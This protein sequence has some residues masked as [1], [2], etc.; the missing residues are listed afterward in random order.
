[1]TTP[2]T[3][4]IT[5]TKDQI[6]AVSTLVERGIDDLEE[7]MGACPDEYTAEDVLSN[8]AEIEQARAAIG[9]LEAASRKANPE[10]DLD[11]VGTTRAI[12]VSELLNP[13]KPDARYDWVCYSE[14]EANA[15]QG[16]GYYSRE[17]GWTT[18]DQAD[19]VTLTKLTVDTPTP[20]ATGDD[21]QWINP[22]L[23]SLT[24]EESFNEALEHYCETFALPQLDARELQHQLSEQEAPDFNGST[25]HRLWLNRICERWEDLFENH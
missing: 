21:A 25:G 8:K 17:H 2:L 3:L 5:L 11:T 10:I 20:K 14:N 6:N 23:E 19:R 22:H 18:K 4:T 24:T 13:P 1:M 7:V 16:R 12:P 9:L 15:N